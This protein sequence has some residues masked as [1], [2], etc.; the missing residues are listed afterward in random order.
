MIRKQD[1]CVS[2]DI[3]M[4]GI[5]KTA[6]FWDACLEMVPTFRAKLTEEPNSIQIIKT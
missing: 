5:R 3:F 6:V 2:F 4:T 1:K